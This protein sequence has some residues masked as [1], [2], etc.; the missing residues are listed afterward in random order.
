MHGLLMLALSRCGRQGAALAAYQGARRVLIEELGTEPDADLQALH[1][2]ILTA[3]C[4]LAASNGPAVAARGVET[5]APRQLP[6]V[7]AHFTGR[8]REL[9]E[10]STVLDQADCHGPLAV[11]VHIGLRRSVVN[12]SEREGGWLSPHDCAGSR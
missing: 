10:L 6:G 1:Q 12:C 8:E 9:A 11:N 5:G 2:Q 4:G 3:D 7:A